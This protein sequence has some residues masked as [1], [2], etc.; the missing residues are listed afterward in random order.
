MIRWLYFARRWIWRSAEKNERLI[1]V[2]CKYFCL[3]IEDR[4]DLFGALDSLHFGLIGWEVSPV[5]LC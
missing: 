2:F 1:D 5:E 3:W 4:S